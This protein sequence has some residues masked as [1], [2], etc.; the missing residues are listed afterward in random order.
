MRHNTRLLR[1]KFI[2]ARE[3][4]SV[5]A[6]LPV[7]SAICG[8]IPINSMDGR[9]IKPPPPAML[10]STPATKAKTVQ[11]ITTV[12][13]FLPL[14]TKNIPADDASAYGNAHSAGFGLR[15]GSITDER[16]KDGSY[17]PGPTGCRSVLWSDGLVPEPPR[18]RTCRWP[19][20]PWPRRRIFHSR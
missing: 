3:V 20:L 15:C 16:G 19:A 13:M 17:S 4:P 9:V 14:R 10:S 6:N 11:T 12:S 18:P 7:P 8:G 5:D 1:A 2:N